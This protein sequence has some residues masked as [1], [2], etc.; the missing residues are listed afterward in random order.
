[1]LNRS[2]LRQKPTMPARKTSM[3]PWWRVR[4][5]SKIRQE[6]VRAAV[7]S[8]PARV[9]MAAPTGSTAKATPRAIPPRGVQPPNQ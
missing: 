7:A 1:M 9:A 4:T 3:R 8:T 6:K 5:A 2:P